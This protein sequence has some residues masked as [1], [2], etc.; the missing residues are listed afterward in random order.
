MEPNYLWNQ[1]EQIQ[2]TD[3]FTPST[4]EEVVQTAKQ[5]KKK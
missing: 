2:I 1:G 5:L 4:V 3:D